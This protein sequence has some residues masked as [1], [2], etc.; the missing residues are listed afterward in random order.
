MYIVYSAVYGEHI[1]CNN[2]LNRVNT[3]ELHAGEHVRLIRRR[4]PLRRRRSPRHS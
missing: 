3:N 2:F 1:D 4:R